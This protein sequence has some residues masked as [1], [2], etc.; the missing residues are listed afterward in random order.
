MCTYIWQALGSLSLMCMGTH[1]CFFPQSYKGNNFRDLMYAS[2]NCIPL[3]IWAQFLK[4]RICSKRSKFFSLR[5]DPKLRKEAKI[6]LAKFLPQN[7][8]LFT[9]K[10]LNIMI[11]CLGPWKLSDTTKCSLGILPVRINNIWTLRK[12]RGA[13]SVDAICGPWEREEGADSVDAMYGSW[14]REGWSDNVDAQF[15]LSRLFSLI[16][17]M[18]NDSERKRQN[19]IHY[20][21]NVNEYS[22]ISL[23]GT[24]GKSFSVPMLFRD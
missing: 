10:Q 24:H 22:F 12:G 5:V 21:H 20:Y 19:F 8:Y 9:L 16:V 13:D 6:I 1:R 14:E 2:L 7:V 11:T 23:V 17:I 18:S 15:H 3:L 4:E